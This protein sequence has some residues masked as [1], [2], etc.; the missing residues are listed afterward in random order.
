ML[1]FLV[2]GG[3]TAFLLATSPALG[4]FVPG[5]LAAL[6]LRLAGL[7]CTG[8]TVSSSTLWYP[9]MGL[10]LDDPYVLSGLPLLVA[11]WSAALPWNGKSLRGLVLA[12]VVLEGF[13]GLVSWS[14]GLCVMRGETSSLHIDSGL[15]LL[16]MSSI[17]IVRA[18]PVLLWILLEPRVRS[19]VFQRAAIRGRFERQRV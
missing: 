10:R 3:L 2:A 16:A 7:D 9:A 6:G 1:S 15:E 5:A 4:L 12:L 17:P 13:G 8:W 18:L 14:V 11:L 19:W